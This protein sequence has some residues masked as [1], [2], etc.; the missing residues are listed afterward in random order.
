MKLERKYLFF[1]TRRSV[2]KCQFKVFML[3]VDN[4]TKSRKLW[5]HEIAVNQLLSEK[6]RCRLLI[7]SGAR[8]VPIKSINLNSK[9]IRTCKEAINRLSPENTM[10]I[11]WAPGHS[12]VE[13]MNKLTRTGTAAI[14]VTIEN[15]R[16]FHTFKCNCRTYHQIIVGAVWILAKPNC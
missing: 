5:S 3:R 13:K 12:D 10:N 8:P 16:P 2:V 15:L 9:S 1:H 14:V 11:A 7:N 4:L 6:S